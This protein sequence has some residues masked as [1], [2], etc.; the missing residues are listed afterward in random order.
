ML[1]RAIHLAPSLTLAFAA[2]ALA[3]DNGQGLLPP[4]G[5][6]SWCAFGGF[7]HPAS[8]LVKLVRCHVCVPL[9]LHQQ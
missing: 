6:N 1:W 8:L 9:V 2:C 4:I 7:E 3:L 5:W